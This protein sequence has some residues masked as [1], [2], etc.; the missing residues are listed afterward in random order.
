MPY[1]HSYPSPQ[2]L[3][4]PRFEKD[5]CGVAMVATLTGVASHDIVKQ[6][7]R[8][9]V[10]LDHRGAVGA[11]E[12]RIDDRLRP[13]STDVIVRT[14]RRHRGAGELSHEGGSRRELGLHL[15]RPSKRALVD[16]EDQ[17]PGQ[18]VPSRQRGQSGGSAQ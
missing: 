14:D 6:G 13:P 11:A 9:L 12:V 17:N 1:E 2:G 10:N 8:A 7:I 4:D 15:Q 5:A 18:D 3:Y 16:D